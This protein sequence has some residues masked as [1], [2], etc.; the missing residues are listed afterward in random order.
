[1]AMDDIAAP[2]TESEIQRNEIKQ[3]ET[4]TGVN[5]RTETVPGLR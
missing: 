4:S 2:L 3:L 1:M 5:T